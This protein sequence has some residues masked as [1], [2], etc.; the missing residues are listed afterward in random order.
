MAGYSRLLTLKAHEF[1]EQYSKLI[2][3]SPIFSISNQIPR[4]KETSHKHPQ[5]PQQQMKKKGEEGEE[6]MSNETNYLSILLQCA[7]RAEDISSVAFILRESQSRNARLSSIASRS[8]ANYLNPVKER[9][10]EKGKEKEREKERGKKVE[11]KPEILF[12]LAR[13]VIAV[14]ARQA[15]NTLLLAATKKSDVEQANSILGIHYY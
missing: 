12:R 6:T 2:Q 13:E 15:W 5:Q 14:N 10:E 7:V 4:D 3:S 11:E 1:K 8:L 9:E